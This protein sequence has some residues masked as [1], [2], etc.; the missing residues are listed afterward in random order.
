MPHPG[1]RCSARQD[2][3]GMSPTL[4]PM[5][6]QALE[7]LART[8]SPHRVQSKT[9][10]TRA[11]TPPQRKRQ[12]RRVARTETA[13]TGRS[14]APLWLYCVATLDEGVAKQA[15][16]APLRKVH[17]AAIGAEVTF[18]TFR[19][20]TPLRVLTVEVR[21]DRRPRPAKARSGRPDT[22]RELFH[23]QYRPGGR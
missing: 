11:S 12:R 13:S 21:Q 9:L 6:R 17:L 8:G 3:R 14:V 5:V 15:F 20:S 18:V 7:L 4:R 23:A 2:G 19:P 16:D 10:V 22:K 1:E